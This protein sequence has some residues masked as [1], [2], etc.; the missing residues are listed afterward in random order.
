MKIVKMELGMYLKI[1]TIELKPH[2][3]GFSVYVSRVGLYDINDKWIK[4]I[5]INQAFLD[6]LLNNKIKL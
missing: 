3:H 5:V 6:V 2:K 1:K 4:W